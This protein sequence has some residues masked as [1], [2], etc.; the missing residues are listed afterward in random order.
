MVYFQLLDIQCI[1][2]YR[3]KAEAFMKSVGAGATWTCFQQHDKISTI[4]IKFLQGTQLCIFLFLCLFITGLSSKKQ[5]KLIQ[6]FQ[7]TGKSAL[8][9]IQIYTSGK[10]QQQPMQIVPAIGLFIGS[11]VYFATYAGFRWISKE[12][13]AQVNSYICPA[14]ISLDQ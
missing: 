13:L 2:K 3:R 7:K 1:T 12:C 10:L 4:T 6:S 11:Y 9:K 5:F 8:D 14:I